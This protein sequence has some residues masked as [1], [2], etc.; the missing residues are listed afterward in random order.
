MTS[1]D[2]PSPPPSDA[3]APRWYRPDR[4]LESLVAASSALALAIVIF[5]VARRLRYPFELEWMEGAVLD[6][7]RV[8]LAGQPL[9]RAPS[10]EFTPYIYTPFYYELCALLARVFGLSLPL[11]R[12]VSVVSSLASFALIADFVRRETGDRLAALASAGLLA[13]TY[14]LTGFWFDVARVDS[15]YV[16]LVLLGTWLARFGRSY[17]SAVGAAIVLFLAFFTK[18]T[19][20]VLAIPALAF[21]L[22][23]SW[24]RGLL[25][26]TLFAAVAVGS[27]AWMN[28]AT[29]GWFGYYVFGAPS[30]HPMLWDRWSALL[31]QFFWAPVAVPVLFALLAIVTPAVRQHGWG[32]WASYAMLLLLALGTSYSS[33]LHRDGFVNV[34]MPGY[35]VLA[36]VAGFG[37][38]WVR[39]AAPPHAASLRAFASASLL[40]GFA[41]LSYDVRRALPTARDVLAGREM[42]QRLRQAQGPMWAAGSGFAACQAGHP[43]ITA[44]AMAMADVF[45]TGDIDIRNRLRDD[46]LR[47]IREKRYASIVLDRGWEMLPPEIA[48]EVRSVYRLQ[49]TLFPPSMADACW[50]RTGYH[51][52][53]EE[54][55]VPR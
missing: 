11:A 51:S 13:A 34:L 14:E 15:L 8:L 50:P 48:G 41:V 52:R 2:P 38:A 26:S 28:R 21:A 19:G 23:G 45:K 20:L 31:L 10:V 12:L 27:V 37:Y 43:E 6:H 3:T 36:I 30:E 18:Q 7:V 25:A 17:G 42:I 46:L 47:T 35:A 1:Q 16:F 40:L 29:N 9:Y 39:R 5:A 54:L 53:P 4:L 33:L 49:T 32:R 22:A 24:R 55:W 44:H